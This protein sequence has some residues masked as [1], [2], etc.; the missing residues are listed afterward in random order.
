MLCHLGGAR[1][2]EKLVEVVQDPFQ[3]SPGHL[4]RQVFRACPTRRRPQGRLRTHWR[5]YVSRLGR[6]R[7][8]IPSEELEDV[9]GEKDVW[10][11]LLR[12]A[13]DNQQKID[14]FKTN[15]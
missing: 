3:M 2:R 5:H 4:P 9:Y 7:F 6:E 1:S 12:P 15:V 13:Q 8:G 14:G 10:G 11:S